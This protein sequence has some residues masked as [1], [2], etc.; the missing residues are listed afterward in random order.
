MVLIHR[1]DLDGTVRPN[2]DRSRARRGTQS[3]IRPGAFPV[4]GGWSCPLW[5]TQPSP[6]QTPGSQPYLLNLSPPQW[7][8][9]V[10][11]HRLQNP[12]PRMLAFHKNILTSGKD[13]WKGSVWWMCV[14]LCNGSETCV[15]EYVFCFQCAN[16]AC[17][18]SCKPTPTQNVKSDVCHWA[19][20]LDQQIDNVCYF[21]NRCNTLRKVHKSTNCFGRSTISSLLYKINTFYWGNKLCQFIDMRQAQ[22]NWDLGSLPVLD[23][24]TLCLIQ[25]YEFLLSEYCPAG[26]LSDGRAPGPGGR[27]DVRSGEPHGDHSSRGDAK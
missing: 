21:S 12:S 16:N 26:E 11:N 4:E 1:R 14:T 15:Y 8:E 24:C 23:E 10:G 6:N 3:E 22:G 2:I 5:D 27:M 13:R 7:T 19:L 25:S 9:R 18:V 20:T 17:F